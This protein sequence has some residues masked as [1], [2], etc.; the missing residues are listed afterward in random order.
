MGKFVPARRPQKHSNHRFRGVELRAIGEP[1]VAVNWLSPRAD[2]TAATPRQD[3]TRIRVLV[4]DDHTLVRQGLVSLIGYRIGMQVVGEASNG[5][6]ALRLIPVLNPDVVLIDVAMP[7]MSGVETT[8][9]ITRRFPGVRI[10]V[11]STLS[12][13]D[14]LVPILRAGAAGFIL[15]DADSEELFRAI[16]AVHYG[17]TYFSPAVSSHIVRKLLVPQRHQTSQPSPTLTVR[18][19]EILNLIADGYSNQE[20]AERLCVS[21]KTVEAHKS[22]MIGKLGLR[23]ALDLVRYAVR[24]QMTDLDA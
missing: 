18:E 3:T 23:G 20:I 15:K 16:E 21:V 5:R 13:A 1:G 9:E 4:V 12:Y 17:N 19:R 6:D 24:Q 11:L 10:L 22:H 2:L 7:V 14:Q 8:R